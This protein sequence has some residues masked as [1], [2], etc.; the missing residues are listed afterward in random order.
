MNSKRFPWPLFGAFAAMLVLG[1]P[2]LVDRL[3]YEHEHVGYGRIVPWGIWVAAYMFFAGLSAGA[4]L[5]STLATVFRV[6]RFRPLVG[7]ALF[8]ALV[9]LGVGVLFVTADLGRP[10]RGYFVLLHSNTS[11]VMVWL[12][13]LYTAYG[14]ILGLKLAV[15]MRPGF[16]ERAAKDG[17]FI[18]SILSLGYR[19][20]PA[21]TAFDRRAEKVLGVAGM[22]VALVLPGC[23]GTLL[24]VVAGRPLWH[25]GLFPVTFVVAAIVSGASA[26]LVLS[27][28]L[29]RGGRAWRST[30]LSLSQIV[31]AFLAVEFV[32][33]TSEVLIARRGEIPS[34]VAV[35]DTITNG[36]FAWVFWVV[37]IGLGTVLPLGLIF[38]PRRPRSLPIAATACLL[39]LVGAFAFRL[40]LL[41]PQQT[42]P[43]IEFIMNVKPATNGEPVYVPTWVEW[44]F[45]I[46]GFGLAGVALLGG[47]RLLPLG[48][49]EEAVEFDLAMQRE[50]KAREVELLEEVV[51]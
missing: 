10:D 38:H 17:G 41:I 31:G 47:Y 34:H 15:V 33:L 40:N 13:W 25:S 44:N 22:L 49:A 51:A 6:E 42:L 7:L 30:L 1:L 26:I 36:P 35:I 12:G 9:S 20:S 14:I 48:R 3:L 19:P 16:A 11:S 46:F 27:L 32:I 28:I 37:Q 29:H 4:F 50:H 2:G 45:L 23:A 18:S 8:T 24:A 39:A 43:A 5:I 21:Q